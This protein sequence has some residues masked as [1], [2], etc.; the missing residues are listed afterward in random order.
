M[1][2][3]STPRLFSFGIA[4]NSKL[5]FP[6]DT[7]LFFMLKDTT[8]HED[9]MCL[10]N[11]PDHK[12]KDYEVKRIVWL[13]KHLTGAVCR[14]NEDKAAVEKGHEVALGNQLTDSLDA[15]LE[16]LQNA[17]DKAL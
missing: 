4:C 9:V 1:L 3:K 5:T 16:N 2:V 13:R 11:D 14:W 8:M 7:L 12:F 6:F 17:E 10:M 15:V